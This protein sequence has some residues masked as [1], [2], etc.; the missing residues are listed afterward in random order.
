[1]D[2][3]VQLPVQPSITV[4]T[5]VYKLCEEIQR[6]NAGML[7]KVSKGSRKN[8]TRTINRQSPT[9]KKDYYT[10]T[11]AKSGQFH[12]EH[13]DGLLGWQSKHDRKGSHP[14]DF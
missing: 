8:F 10:T 7:D 11:S 14:I 5:A 12:D 1:M 2:D 9:L 13:F 6:I 4:T 3:D